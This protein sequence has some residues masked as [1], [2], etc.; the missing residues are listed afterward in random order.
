MKHVK[1]AYVFQNVLLLF[2]LAVIWFLVYKVVKTENERE[3]EFMKEVLNP[4]VNESIVIN[5]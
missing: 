4:G 5:D 1:L 2:F 3:E